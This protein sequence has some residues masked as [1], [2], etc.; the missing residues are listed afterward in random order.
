M[1]RHVTKVNLKILKQNFRNQVKSSQLKKVNIFQQDQKS[2]D[3]I[4]V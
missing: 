4:E 1:N 2:I 3:A